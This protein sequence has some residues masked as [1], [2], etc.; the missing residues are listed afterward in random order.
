MSKGDYSDLLKNRKRSAADIESRPADMDK[1]IAGAKSDGSGNTAPPE[2][3]KRIGAQIPASTYKALKKKALENDT[4][5]TT[6]I[7]QWVDEYV[8]D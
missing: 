8:S 2:P 3:L 4:N 7:R 6:L 1:F 5:V